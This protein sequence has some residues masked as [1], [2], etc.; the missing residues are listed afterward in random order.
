MVA[1]GTGTVNCAPAS[2]TK[3]DSSSC[4]AVPDPGWQVTGW[5][6]ACVATGANASCYLPK[7]QQDAVSAVSFGLI[8]PNTYYVSASVVL[9]NG[10]VS[11]T[12]DTVT[13]GGQSTC[14]AIPDIGYQVQN[15]GGACASWG[16]N[17]QCY[18]SKIKQDQVAT[19]SFALLPP[20][21]YTVSATVTGGNG[22][23]SCTPGTVTAGGNSACTAVPA[24]GY[25]VAG[26]T[27]AC[28][29]T[30]NAGQCD[31]TNIQTD[32]TSTV[33]FAALPLPTYTVSA[34]AS[35]GN[36]TVSCAPSPVTQGGSSSCAATPDPGYLVAGWNGAC[37]ATGS[38]VQ[39][40]LTNIQSNQDS[41]VSFSAIP[42]NSYHI[43]ATVVLGNGSVGCTPTTV[44]K[45]G[46]S[47]CTAVPD[48]GWQVQSWSG[49]CATAGSNAQCFLPK[50]R[51]DEV[52]TV[53]FGPI[54][55][56]TH[57]VSATVTGGNGAVRCS[58]TTV[59]KNDAS[60][61]LA[62]PDAGYQVQG[63]TGACAGAGSNPQCYLT[64]VQKDAVSTV[65]FVALPANHYSVTAAVIG[66][67]G[68]VSCTPT[69]VTAGQSSSCTAVPDPGYQVQSW[70]GV[71]L[72]AGSATQ[73]SLTNIQTDQ[74]STVSFA[75]IPPITYRVTATV[76]S[77]NGT[78]N[79]GP[80]PVVKGG[81]SSC[82]ALPAAGWQVSGWTG[83]CAA[84]GANAQCYLPKVQKNE[85]ATVSF[86]PLPQNTY[87]VSAIVAV[88]LGSVTCSP[89]SV[90]SGGASICTATPADGYQVS[91]WGGACSSWASN[92]QCYL[93]KIKSNQVSAVSFM[94]LPVNA[95]TISATVESGNGTL[96]CTPTSVSAG[97][98][99]TCTAVPEPG[100]QIANWT[101]ACAEAGK[102]ATCV[103]SNVSSNQVASVNLVKA[104]PPPNPI[105]VLP[106]WGAA[107][108]GL[109]L[110]AAARRRL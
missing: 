12:P 54:L 31:L 97:G 74:S 42:V 7:I 17:A 98:T 90:A 45:G 76:A 105:P 59:T 28:A 50:I 75:L 79:C 46:Q 92:A 93:T 32:Q 67:N 41:T 96:S 27:G 71:C 34:T 68:T 94:L 91:G 36:G 18:L 104:T 11:C 6:G 30:G 3:G 58:P 103:I 80:S 37:A 109:G 14:T 101:G 57:S 44:A 43:S 15:W 81:S 20:A 47:A 13:S 19:V 77:G 10:T 73:C 108:M 100:Y 35:G 61:C 48:S 21:H 9:G 49:P 26:W 66:G 33:S 22:A 2:V 95:Y 23:V 107:L 88:G 102:N 110:L 106:I 40:A 86:V 4:T 62:I 72:L 8:P 64:K 56:A 99:I 63:W 52:A 16:R 51:Q 60:T 53:S 78:V 29:A 83:A 38:N 1:S 39:C 69:S 25:E 85:N 87:S 70:S 65:S 55:P 82:T 5:T 89:G 84:T 24:I